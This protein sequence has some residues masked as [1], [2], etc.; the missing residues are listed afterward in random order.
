MKK[1]RYTPPGFES[2]RIFQEASIP[3]YYANSGVY[4]CQKHTTACRF[5]SVPPPDGGCFVFPRD[6]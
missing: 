1:K 5:P 2:E 3:C 6:S 4:S